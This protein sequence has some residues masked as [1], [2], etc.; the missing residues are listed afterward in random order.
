MSNKPAPIPKVHMDCLTKTYCRDDKQ[1][2]FPVRE[3]Q[4]SWSAH[5]PEYDPDDFT[6]PHILKGPAWA[7]PNL[8]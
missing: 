2:R 3:D 6:M 1:N 5:Y 7:D 4:I 8:R